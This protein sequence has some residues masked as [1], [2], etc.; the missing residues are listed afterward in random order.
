MEL[1][2]DTRSNS[3]SGS[4]GGLQQLDTTAAA[5]EYT[6]RRESASLFLFRKDDGGEAPAEET[7]HD[8]V[9]REREREANQQKCVATCSP[10]LSSVVCSSRNSAAGGSGDDW[11]PWSGRPRVA[12]LGST[13]ANT[14]A[15]THTHTRSCSLRDR[16]KDLADAEQQRRMEEEKDREVCSTMRDRDAPVQWRVS[17][18]RL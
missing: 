3:E 13:H 17:R 1:Q 12:S 8:V 18:R 5:G 16:A 4:S 2:S 7:D 15:L 9:K 11:Q 6:G 10:T 14:L